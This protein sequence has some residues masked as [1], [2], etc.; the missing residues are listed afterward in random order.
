LVEIDTIGNLESIC[1]QYI[2]KEFELE[3]FQSRLE[4]LIISDEKKIEIEKARLDAV[5]RLEEIRFC[6]LETN[7]YKYG[8]VV[9]TSLIELVKQIR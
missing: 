7:F 8:V 5:N 4:T 1:K 9:A 2:D 6:S 3:E